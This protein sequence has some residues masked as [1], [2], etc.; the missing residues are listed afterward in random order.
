MIQKFLFPFI[1]ILA[2]FPFYMA[3]VRYL[4]GRRSGATLRVVIF[5]LAFF[6][7]HAFLA[8]AVSNA[9]FAVPALRTGD[10]FFILLLLV[11][12]VRNEA[13]SLKRLPLSERVKEKNSRRFW[14]P[15]L[16]VFVVRSEEHTSE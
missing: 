4:C 13:E 3:I 14:I 16:L 9:P 1:P 15:C 2:V 10:L 8:R 11:G 12:M 7:W 6:L 5:S